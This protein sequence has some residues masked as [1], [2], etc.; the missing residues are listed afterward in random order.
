MKIV[1]ITDTERAQGYRDW[2][3]N[4]RDGRKE[5][6]RVFRPDSVRLLQ[7]LMLPSPTV[8]LYELVAHTLR[9]DI[10]FLLQITPR[11]VCEIYFEAIRR[12]FN[13]AALM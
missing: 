11:S 7:I 8:R 3:V 2:S 12:R 10:P 4:F 9:R 1:E 5:T 13:G 6:L